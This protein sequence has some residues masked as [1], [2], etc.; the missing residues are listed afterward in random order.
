MQTLQLFY[1][2]HFFFFSYG[3]VEWIAI[4]TY[5]KSLK[6]N[7]TFYSNQIPCR[8]QFLIIDA[9]T[10]CYC[11]SH[12]LNWSFVIDVKK[13]FFRFQCRIYLLEFTNLIEL[14]GYICWF[15]GMTAECLKKYQFVLK[16]Q[17]HKKET[18]FSV[19]FLLAVFILSNFTLVIKIF[20]V[21][22]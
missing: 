2:L 12:W 13:L 16:C 20:V 6:Q 8:T 19:A 4:T 22:N 15:G 5:N 14:F 21:V 10:F 17:V 9:C 7:P 3:T 1:S 18:H 11:F